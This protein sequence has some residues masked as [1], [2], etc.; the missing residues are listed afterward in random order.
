MLLLRGARD[1]ATAA[2][3]C[4]VTATIGRARAY[5]IGGAKAGAGG[6]Q[7]GA[8]LQVRSRPLLGAAFVQGGQNR[9]AC[10]IAARAR[11][12]AAMGL[13]N[14][15]FMFTGGR[16]AGVLHCGGAAGGRARTRGPR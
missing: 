9:C 15:C 7:L 10:C 2:G 16:P 5:L 14:G 13:H 6:E 11:A 12:V 3:A 8:P 1:G 4:D